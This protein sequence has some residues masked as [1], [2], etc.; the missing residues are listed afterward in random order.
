MTHQQKRALHILAIHK[1]IRV[2]QSNPAYL[3]LEAYG[4][5]KRSR[6]EYPCNFHI[7][8]EGNEE[9]D[10]LERSGYYQRQRHA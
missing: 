6:W 5:A 8:K 4:H 7:T 2:R 10:R 9:H 3:V 1:V